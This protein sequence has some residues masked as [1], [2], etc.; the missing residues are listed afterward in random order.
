[1]DC[2]RKDANEESQ[3][4]PVVCNKVGPS[5]I[6]LQYSHTRQYL[7]QVCIVFHLIL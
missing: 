3:E 6:T 4:L 7:P 5:I 1:M 2:N